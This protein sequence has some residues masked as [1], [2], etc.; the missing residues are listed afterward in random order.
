MSGRDPSST[1]KGSGSLEIRLP[2]HGITTALPIVTI[3][4]SCHL[5]WAEAS[6]RAQQG[7]QRRNQLRQRGGRR[8]ADG[9]L[10]EDG[11]SFR[12]HTQARPQR[13]CRRLQST[14]CSEKHQWSA[15]SLDDSMEAC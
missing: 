2:S 3:G 14:C 10:R 4:A 7:L 12:R 5:P 9:L 8:A 15:R 11:N 6:N 13:L 1:N